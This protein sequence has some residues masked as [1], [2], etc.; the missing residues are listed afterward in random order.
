M[1]ALNCAGVE[2]SGSTP[3]S[4]SRFCTAGSAMVATI[5]RFR[6]SITAWGVP[7]GAAM[8]NQA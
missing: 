3:I 1:N 4:I 6:R 8:P 5:S 2:L 7:A